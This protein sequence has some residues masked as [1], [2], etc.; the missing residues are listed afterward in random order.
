[1][2]WSSFLSAL[3]GGSF[4]LAGVLVA[5]KLESNKQQSNENELITGILKGIHDE[6]DCLWGLYSSRIG[7]M[8]ESLPKDKPLDVFW[9]ITQDYFTFYNA[10]ATLLGRIKDVELRKLIVITYS[11]LKGMVDTYRMNNEL[12]IKFEAA[13]FLHQETQ[14]EV[15]KQQLGARYNAMVQYA[16]SLQETH[17]SCKDSVQKLLRELDKNG[18]LSR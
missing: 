6:V 2:D 15:H 18:A 17:L 9:P 13:A 10:N 16:K 5:H 1:M 11:N 3:V 12:V 4:T 7:N 14:T 8:T